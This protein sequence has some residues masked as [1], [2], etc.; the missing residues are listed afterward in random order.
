M[1][2]PN[3]VYNWRSPTTIP[4]QAAVSGMPTY[5]MMPNQAQQPQAFIPPPLTQGNLQQRAAQ[6][7]QAVTLAS[8][9][10]HQQPMYL[11]T[12]VPLGGAVQIGASQAAGD[13]R[14]GNV[15]QQQ[16]LSHFSPHYNQQQAHVYVTTSLPAG[17]AQ[18]GQQVSDQRQQNIGAHQPQHIQAHLPPQYS[19]QQANYVSTAVLTANGSQLNTQAG[20]Q[21][22]QS[23][24]HQQQNNNHQQQ[25]AFG[26]QIFASAAGPTQ[27][28]PTYEFVYNQQ[29][30][31][32]AQA[33]L[34]Y[35]YH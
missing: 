4:Q 31:V 3:F 33:N 21:R 28:A 30:A 12:S 20:D 9:Y 23:T 15:G 8:Q 27:F 1:P 5:I 26:Q 22:Q 35:I 14:Q 7:L 6:H 25:A 2:P 24:G 34:P 11:A 29:A 18:Y 13:Q 17:G 19:Q 32:A 16:N 10:S